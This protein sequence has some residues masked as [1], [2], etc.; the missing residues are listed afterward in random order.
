MRILMIANYLP[1]PQVSGGRIRI[2]NLLRRVASRHEVSLAALLE[3]PEDAQGVSHLRQFCARV[4]TASFPAHQRSRLAK[5]PGM[6]RYALQ[7]KP[8]DLMLLHSEE[9]LG[10]IRQ[11]FAVNA[12]D[13]VQIESV[14]GLYLEELPQNTSY[15]T[16]Q[17]FQNVASH[18]F[19]RISRVERRRY[20]KVRAWINSV[21]MRHWEPR[22]AENFD[23]CTT[24]SE[25]D[26]QLLRKANPRLQIDVIPNGV[27]IEK[28]QRLPLASENAPASLMFIGNMGYPPCVDA[29][30]YFCSE[31]W[32]LIRQAITRV[33]FWIVGGDPSPEVLKLDGDGVHVTGRVE[34]VVPYYRQS[35][36]CLVPLR[37]GGGTRL[38]ILE[39]MALGRPVVSTSIGCE[40]LDVVDGEH[41]FI[42][43]TPEQFAQK[44]VR[45]LLDRQLA[46]YMCANGRQLVEARYDWDKIAKRLMDVYDMIAK[47]GAEAI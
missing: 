10:K 17:M 25:V 41:L 15:R 23:R 12:F 38:K 36:V 32:P 22:Y 33:E 30:L 43:D 19:A 5:A 18:Q 3:S 34:E 21:S 16:I 6:L 11:L 9:L 45:L 47:P 40:G 27:D 28:Y 13:I 31:I 24:V 46:Q 42:A 7:R 4:E 44:T 39:A 35:T 8:P 2:Y 14:M 26:Q 1:Y 29:V 20:S 37:A